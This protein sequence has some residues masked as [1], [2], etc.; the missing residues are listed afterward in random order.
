[1]QKVEGTQVSTDKWMDEQKWYINTAENYSPLKKEGK[2]AIYDNMDRPS[3]HYAK[4]KELEKDECCM[5]SLI[6]RILKKR[7]H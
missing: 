4:W 1:M 6:Y 7:T 5:I 2:S 3:G